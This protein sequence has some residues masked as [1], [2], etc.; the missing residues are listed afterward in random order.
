VSDW[1]SLTD[2]QRR[3]A[4]LV[5]SGLTKAQIGERMYRSR[6]AVDFHLGQIFRKLGVNTRH[7]LAR[8]AIGQRASWPDE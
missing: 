3:V 6:H 1:S 7:Q 5:A 8:L 2:T 4:T